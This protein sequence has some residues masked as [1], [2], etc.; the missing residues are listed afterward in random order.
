MQVS[1]LKN[2]AQ[3]FSVKVEPTDIP[4][5]CQSIQSEL[6][7]TRVSRSHGFASALAES[8]SLICMDGE[9]ISGLKLPAGFRMVAISSGVKQEDVE[10]RYAQ[11]RTAAA[12][13][14]SM[15]LAKM[16]EMGNLDQDDYKRFFR[17]YL[18]EKMT[19]AEF[20]TRFGREVE[21]EPAGTYFVQ[22]AADHH[23]LESRRV[24]QFREF[25]KQSAALPLEDKNRFILMDKAGHL[26][27]ASH[28]SYMNDARLGSDECDLLVSMVRAREKSGL[29]GARMTDRGCGGTVAVLCEVTDRAQQAIDELV[30]AYQHRT[31]IQPLALASVTV[32][33][34]V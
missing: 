25:I 23:I 17:S 16:R 14:H 22:G 5:I 1:A 24:K 27:Y 34:P 28:L 3:H 21:V 13:A 6:L 15:I 11:T 31:G 18:P 19:G 20:I 30:G 26:M 7:G 10:S 2:F 32:Q 29:Y 4:D 8:N 12:I 9:S 33:H